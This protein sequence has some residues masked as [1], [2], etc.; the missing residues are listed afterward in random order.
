MTLFLPDVNVLVAAL[1]PRAR[2]HTA[3]RAWL[4]LVVNGSDEL[5][6]IPA[7]LVGTI[8]VAT[9]PRIFDP[10]A[11]RHVASRFVATLRRA[12]GSHDLRTGSEVWNRFER[13]L[14][15]DPQAR[16]NL[17]PDAWIAA[18]AMAHGA[19]VATADRGM[20]RW[21]GLDWCDPADS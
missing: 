17:V 13:L 5:A 12:H 20:A 14:A 21:P 4:E 16:G 7:T 6:L 19:R 2:R 15:D 18:T 1:H 10:P 11:D 9:D 3:Y 8:R